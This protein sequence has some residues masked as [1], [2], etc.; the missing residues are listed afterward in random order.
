MSRCDQV[1]TAVYGHDA[2]HVWV[3]GWPRGKERGGGGGGGVVFVSYVCV[4]A[5]VCACIR[6]L[7]DRTKIFLVSK[8]TNEVSSLEATEV[9]VADETRD[10]V[11]T[12]GPGFVAFKQHRKMTQLNTGSWRSN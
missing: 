7:R 12:W 2:M 1:F 8:D 4:C 5:D 9:V 6:H 3:V 10:V 11:L